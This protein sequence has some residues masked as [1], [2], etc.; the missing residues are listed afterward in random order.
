[1]V[2]F[3]PEAQYSFVVVLPIDP[4][5]V[6]GNRY[7]TIVLPMSERFVRLTIVG[8]VGGDIRCEPKKKP[9]EGIWGPGGEMAL[10]GPNLIMAMSLEERSDF[11]EAIWR[12][13][14]PRTTLSGL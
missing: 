3:G 11:K 13:D 10:A 2:S 5:H 7:E 1:M 14:I 12:F 6:C 8:G 9:D 4:D